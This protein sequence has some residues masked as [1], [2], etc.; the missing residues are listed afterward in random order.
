MFFYFSINNHVIPILRVICILRTLYIYC[1]FF[2][3]LRG[4]VIAHGGFDFVQ[5]RVLRLIS[6]FSSIFYRFVFQ[7]LVELIFYIARFSKI[8]VF[9]SLFLPLFRPF[10]FTVLVSRITVINMLF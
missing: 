10:H 5:R 9:H 2:L 7:T 4:N 3:L 1:F 6:S 8:K